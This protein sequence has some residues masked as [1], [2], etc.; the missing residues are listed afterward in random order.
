M[1]RFFLQYL[2]P[3]L[4]PSVVYVLWLWYSQRRAIKSGDTPPPFTRGG[5]FWAILLGAVLLVTSLAVLAVTG[6]VQPDSGVYQAPYLKDGEIIGP[7]YTPP[8]E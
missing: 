2:L 8:A 5:F 1:S 3:L 4:A 7:T 6:G